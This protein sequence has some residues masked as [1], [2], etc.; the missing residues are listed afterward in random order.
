MIQVINHP[1]NLTVAE[2][3]ALQIKLAAKVI[4]EDC[5][6]EIQLIA[7]VDVAY[8][9]NAVFAAVAVFTVDPL[10]LLE[11]A[12]AV[13]TPGFPYIPGLLSF[14]EIPSI[15]SALAKLSHDPDLIICDGQGIAHPRRCG[16]ASH[17]GLLFDIPTIGCAKSH[18]YGEYTQP[19]KHRGDYAEITTHAEVIGRVLRTQDNVKPVFVSIGHKIS[20]QTASQ[21]VLKLAPDF[22]LPETTR[23]ADKLA[24]ALRATMRKS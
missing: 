12:T 13:H 7:G 21:W 15:S 2:A 22:R 24:N 5:F 14:R 8:S 18:L 10:C 11:T 4:K 23:C 3:K 1:W 6:A 9:E 20:L 17:L 19:G 16:L